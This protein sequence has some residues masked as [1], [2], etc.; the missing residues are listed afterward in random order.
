M[1]ATENPLE[2]LDHLKW[3][4]R[5]N[6]IVPTGN[7]FSVKVEEQ[8][9]DLLDKNE[10]VLWL[11]PGLKLLRDHIL[12]VDSFGIIQQIQSYTSF[13]IQ[14]NCAEADLNA[15]GK[16]LALNSDLEFLCPGLIDLHLHAPQYAYTGTATDKP[17]MGQDGWLETY[18]FPAER[19]LRDDLLH[20]AHVYSSVVRSTLKHG[21]TTALYFRHWTLNPVKY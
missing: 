10:N 11:G 4:I 21:T 13:I 3:I 1:V 9:Y 2:Y 15:C 17:L 19:R 8:N 18:T 7:P 16:F 14:Y 20:A 6:I 12:T 5:G